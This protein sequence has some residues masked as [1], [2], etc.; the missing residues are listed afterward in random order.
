[1]D[2]TG[3][4]S[5]EQFDG[6][7]CQQFVLKASH[8]CP[9]HDPDARAERA[10]EQR[11]EKAARLELQARAQVLLSLQTPAAFALV[12]Q[13]LIDRGKVTW[14]DVAQVADAEGFKTAPSPLPF[15]L[16]LSALHAFQ[17]GLQSRLVPARP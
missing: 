5:A 8:F 1:L 7:P 6:R 4:C 13:G 17:S 3:W 14:A 10:E 15:S 2:P 12:L 9:K 11:R 16:E